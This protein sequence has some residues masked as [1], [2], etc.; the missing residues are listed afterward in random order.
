MNAPHP[1]VT[2]PP[3]HFIANRWVAPASGETLPMIDP[4]DGEPFAAIA[5]GTA[6]DVDRAVGAAQHARDGIWGRLA[7]VEKGRLLA[8]LA[9]AIVDHA[10]QLAL[11]EARD[12]GKPLAQAR[13]D[14]TASARYFEFYGGACDKLTGET[15]PYPPQ[16][17]V[18]TWREPHG[19][20]GHIIPWNYPL[21]IFGRSV[22]GALA[23]GNACVV[24][25]AEDAC[26]SLLR[27]AELA[28]G[29]GFPEGALN[30][31]TGLGREAGA[32]L[33]AHRGI[34]HLSFTGS[35]PT[36]A[37]VAAE[38]AKRHCPV[39]LEL[40]GKGPQIVF[41]DADLDAALPVIVN[42]IVQNAGQTCSAG[43]RLL[44]EQS[45]YEEVL[46]KLGDRFAALKVGPALADLDCGPLIRA[47][48]LE[49]VHGFLA[50]AERDGF[51]TVAKG[52]IVADAPRGGYY[53]EPH[54]L[55]DVAPSCRLGC[56]EVFGPVLAAMPFA[57]EADAVR[58]ANGTDFGLVAGVWTRDGG[59]QLRMAR[60]VRSGQVFVNN[61][62]AGGGV[63]LPFGGVK[64]SGYGREKGFEA[65]YGF[66]T[67]KTVVLLHG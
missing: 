18:L 43:S 65:L 40:G 26:L 22:G 45:R 16:Y 8:K 50:D 34:E 2:T 58:I 14:V 15:I 67:L 35:P 11:I 30:I 36:G 37:F 25:P 21:Q 55:R 13:N 61:Y 19:V 27:V 5:F 49:R 7:P 1:A 66:T 31:V 6:E 28:A 53:V 56:E 33:A 10:E 64:S 44:V 29:V 52:E 12:C 32:A 59:R 3:E 20:T 42:A 41:A 57:D 62:G 24:K 60:A 46:A 51:A 9:R 17:T 63:E 54:L 4:S 48:Q 38:A 39:T 23:A 47:G